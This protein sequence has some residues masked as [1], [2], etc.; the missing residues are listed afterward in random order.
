M[1]RISNYHSH[2]ALCGHAEGKV[3]DYIKEAIK[4]NYEEVGIS[5]HAPIPVYFV[6]EKMHHDLWLF[7]MMNVDDLENDYL[8][9]LDY[10]IKKYPN[11]NILKGLEV[12]YIPSKDFY[13]HYLLSK[14]EYLNLGIH[15][16]FVNGNI[17]NTYSTLTDEDIENYAKTIEEAL[18]TNYFSCLVH[19]DLFM[20][21]IK[22]FTSF[23][24]KISRRIIEACIKNDVY[25]EINGNGKDRYPRKEFWEIVKEY[26]D[27]KILINSD[28]H[29]IKDYHG[30]NI[31][32]VM[33]FAEELGLNICEKMIIKHNN[34]STNFIGHRGSSYASVV[35]NTISGFKEGIK[36]NYYAL[37]CDVRISKDGVYY[38]HHDPTI[39]ITNNNFTQ[40]SLQQQGIEEDTNLMDLYWDQLTKL[41]LYYTYNNQTYYDKLILFEDYIKLCSENNMKCIIELKYTN[42][43]NTEDTSKIDGLIDIIKQ[44]KMM[45]YVFILSSMRN[46]LLYIK[47]KYPLMNLVLLTGESTTNM[48]SIE[49]CIEHNMHFD[50][51]HKLVNK[52]MINELRKH[53]LSS[54]VW[55]VNDQQVGDKFVDMDVDFITTDVLTK[56]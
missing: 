36:R 51:Y 52:K 42:G 45:D 7:Q 44:Y 31:Q 39:T 48:D 3:E 8:K 49:W 22:E 28:A 1:K 10:C 55:T 2:I 30:E 14:V 9:Q 25:L 12:E 5:D 37:E 54:N 23:H 18:Q 26:K 53:S 43:I 29:Y 15:Y 40:T 17:V 56:K 35:N 41:D 6:G 4:H 50:A 27:A 32:R 38:I 19:P 47:E 20:Y 34:T 46:C 11:I 16:F 33:K 24:E 13:Y 21:K